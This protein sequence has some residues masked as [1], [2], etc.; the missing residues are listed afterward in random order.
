M[1]ADEHYQRASWVRTAFQPLRDMFVFSGR[2]TRTEVV[3]FFLLG[4]LANMGRFTMAPPFNVPLAAFKLVWGFVWSFPWIALFA[5]RLH[6]Q[7]RAGWWALLLMAPYAVLFAMAV[8]TGTLSPSG[9]P[10][11]WSPTGPSWIGFMSVWAMI[12]VAILIL[13]LLPGTPG[14]NRYGADP[15]LASEPQQTAAA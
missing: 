6:D 13:H 10:F 15:R 2:S 9:P 1:E 12:G 4:T 3:T 7:G 5:R 8:T 14:F 11:E